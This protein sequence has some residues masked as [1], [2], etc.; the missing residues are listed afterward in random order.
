MACTGVE[1]SRASALWHCLLLLLLCNENK[2][3]IYYSNVFGRAAVQAGAPSH[4]SERVAQV[5]AQGASR[6][7][8]RPARLC[9]QQALGRRKVNQ[10]PVHGGWHLPGLRREKA[11]SM[12][13]SRLRMSVSLFFT[14]LLF[15]HVPGWPRLSQTCARRHPLCQ[16]CPAPARAPGSACPAP[17]GGEREREGG[18]VQRGDGDAAPCRKARPSA[19][20]R[21]RACPTP[22]GAPA[23]GPRQRCRRPVTFP[24]ASS[25]CFCG[26]GRAQNRPRRAAQP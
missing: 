25:Q 16:A 14:K 5:Q 21:L 1:P 17:K 3:P 15:L 6:E 13:E 8:W 19:A 12:R 11:P 20:L 22:F 4:P 9:P 10:E 7:A 2:Q 18:R 26:R 24:R 23:R